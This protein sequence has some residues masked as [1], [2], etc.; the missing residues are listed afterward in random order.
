MK[1]RKLNEELDKVLNEKLSNYYLI[2]YNADFYHKTGDSWYDLEPDNWFTEDKGYSKE[3]INKIKSLS[4]GEAYY[5]DNDNQV[6]VR[7]KVKHF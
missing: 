4:Y 2:F 3:D 1:I 6:I 5:L 7:K